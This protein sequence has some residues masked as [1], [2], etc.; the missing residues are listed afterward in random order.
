MERYHVE[1]PITRTV[2][3]VLYEELP[4]QGVMKNL[5]EREK[6]SEDLSWHLVTEHQVR[7]QEER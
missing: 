3:Q 4:I 2:Y 7:W 6:K 1:M 5:M